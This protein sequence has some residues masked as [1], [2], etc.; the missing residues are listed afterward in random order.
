M[1]YLDSAGNVDPTAG[2]IVQQWTAFHATQNA[3]DTKT[4]AGLKPPASALPSG[5]EK[6]A[7]RT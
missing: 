3:V 4:A 7:H 5:A 6:A 2:P 1:A